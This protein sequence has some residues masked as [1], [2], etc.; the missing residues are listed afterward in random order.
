MLKFYI[1]LVD[2]H[3]NRISHFPIRVS[4]YIYPLQWLDI[5]GYIRTKHFAIHLD[6]IVEPYEKGMVTFEQENHENYH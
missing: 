5:L 6:R 2:H 1:S 4:N 3:S